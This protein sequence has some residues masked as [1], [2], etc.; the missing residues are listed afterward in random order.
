MK[1]IKKI[2]ILISALLLVKCTP[3]KRLNRLIDRHPEL[4]ENVLDTLI[5]HDSVIV[6]NFVHDTTT[7]FKYHDS[8]VIV[9]NEKVYAEYIFDTITKEIH[10]VIE[11]KGD[12]IR[13]I[14]EIPFQV[15]MIKY[16]E[17]TPLKKYLNI[18][19]IIVFCLIALAIFK[20]I[21]QIFF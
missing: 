18:G 8:I 19:I 14:K 1:K 9:N 13:I 3:Q 12:T 5:L 7:I 20:Q 4:T 11:C 21:R 2:V 15:E 10:H 16:I 17:N 6:P